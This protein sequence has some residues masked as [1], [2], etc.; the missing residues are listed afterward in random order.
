VSERDIFT[1]AREMT[2]PVARAAYLDGACGGDPGL[3]SRVEALLLAH[4]RPDSLLDRPAV[5]VHDPD[6]DATQALTGRPELAVSASQTAVGEN[7]PTDDEALSFLAPPRRP[8]SL[9]RIGHYEV[10]QVLGNGGFGIVFRAFDDV[11]HRVVA[12]KVLSPLMATTSPARKRFLREARSS[13]QVRHENVVQVYEVGEQPLP[14]IAMEFIPGE[15][16]QQRLDRLGPVEPAEVVRVGR[17]LAEGL[18]AAHAQD[19]IHRD[20]KPG[21][22]LLEGGAG[23]VRIT[24][25]GLARAADDASISQSGIIAGTPMYMAPEQ[26]RGEELDQRADL[27][28]LGS[29]L[30]QMAAGRPPFR[31]NSTVAVLKRVA[32]D[33]PRDIREVIPE[34]PQ[35]LCAIIAKLHAKDPGE[36]YQSAREVAEVL[37][38]CEAQLKANAKLKDYSRIP[39][40]NPRRSGRRKWL[41]AAAVLLLP[42]IAL[43]MT[44]TAGV[45]HLLLGRQ[46]TSD[47]NTSGSGPQA[48]AAAGWN[49]W[50]V[51]APPPAVAP[52]DAAQARAHQEAWAKYLGVPVKY[53]NSIGMRF[54]L[55]PPGEFMMGSTPEGIETA[56]ED[57]VEDKLWV[58]Y[59][60]SEV[61]KHKVILTRPFYLGVNEVTQADYK[62]VMGWNPS[63]FAPTGAGKE[64]IA[65]M[66]TTNHPVEGANWYDA[67]EFCV[68]LSKQEKLKP[69]YLRDREEISFLNGTG[70]RLP[71]EAEWEF[72]CRAGTATRFWMGDTDDDFVRAGWFGG[73]SG[74]GVIEASGLRTHAAGELPS[75]PFGLSDMHGNVWEWVQ[76][77]WEPTFYGESAQE[78][79]INPNNRLAT[80]SHPVMRGGS[81]CFTGSFCRSSIR[82]AYHPAASYMDIGFRVSLPVDTVK[83]AKDNPSPRVVTPFTD[84]DVRRIAALPAAEQ[85]EEAREELMRRNLGFDGKMEHKIEDGVVTDF[86]IVTDHVTDISPIRIFDS[87]RVLD[88]GGTITAFKP[89]GQLKDLSPLKGMNLAGL[90]HLNLINTKVADAGM[91]HFDACKD[92][93]YLNLANTKVTDRGLAHFKDCKSL[94]IFDLTGTKVTDRGLAHFKDCKDLTGIYAIHTEIGDAGLAHFQDCKALTHLYLA[95]T[96][97]GDAGLAHFKGMPLMMLWIHDTGITDLS[98]LQ[99]MPLEDIRLTPKRITWGLDVLRDIKSLKTIGIDWNQSWPAAEFWGRYDKGEFKE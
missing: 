87:L 71:S 1:A 5:A 6:P 74:L 76:D 45:T 83:G 51:D 82:R 15:T 44:E 20:I 10:L 9:G 47:A 2:D 62:K 23:R 50:P 40:S 72:A 90:T 99:G 14:Y 92:L 89:N 30:Y 84:A 31:A 35:W 18:A 42:V 79:A 19:L 88:C 48:E 38:D 24:D 80:N 66:D 4:D 58:A 8:D 68:N 60:Q 63:Y 91:V 97:V 25:F 17:Q 81:S 94:T 12:V 43:A 32:D 41:A 85:V 70:Y 11:L 69:F 78:P 93:T 86:R 73:K 61:P 55:V 39:R 57:A 53:T 75:N 49:G 56:L 7:T 34:T 77:L 28:S 52:F 54:R 3:R 21:N 37:A 33:T 22:V 98:P 27:F 65:G 64:A 46:S 36:R 96:E 26:A 13:A 29:V 59:I 16:L 67:A 95:G